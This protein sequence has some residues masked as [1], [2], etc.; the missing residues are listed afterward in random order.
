MLVARRPPLLSLLAH[1]KQATVR[2]AL[3]QQPGVSVGQ[4]TPTV[5]YHQSE[6]LNIGFDKRTMA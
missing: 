2:R 3:Y 6:N 1:K 4:N 5:G